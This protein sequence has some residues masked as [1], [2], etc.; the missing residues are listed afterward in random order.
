MDS[1]ETDARITRAIAEQRAD[2]QSTPSGAILTLVSQLA[3]EGDLAAVS[4]AFRRFADAMPANAD[5]VL[6]AIPGKVHE[7][8]LIGNRRLSAQ[9]LQAWTNAHPD[10]AEKLKDSLA[11]PLLFTLAVEA[12]EVGARGSPAPS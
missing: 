6:A 10:W 2:D 7:A 8:Y 9:V 4:H 11:D 5:F 1:A 12:I 3:A